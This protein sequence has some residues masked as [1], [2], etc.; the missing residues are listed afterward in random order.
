MRSDLSPLN[1][2]NRVAFELCFEK[3][4]LNGSITEVGKGI[5]KDDLAS[6]KRNEKKKERQETS[7]EA[8]MQDSTMRRKLG[9]F[10]VPQG[11]KL[12][13]AFTS[14]TRF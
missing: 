10:I 11:V 2:L 1:H 5:L 14:R 4:A 3:I 12:C 13:T 9:F 6:M 8:I 7:C